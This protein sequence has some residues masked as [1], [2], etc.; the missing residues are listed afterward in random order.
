MAG[1]KI[2][3]SGRR[4]LTG[5]RALVTTT[6]MTMPKATAAAMTM[7]MANTTMMTMQ[8][9]TLSLSMAKAM[10]MTSMRMLPRRDG[11]SWKRGGHKKNYCFAT[12]MMTGGEDLF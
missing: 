6:T 1:S 2:L 11:T 12:M 10:R 7:A 4:V 9:S 5:L 8:T 3:K